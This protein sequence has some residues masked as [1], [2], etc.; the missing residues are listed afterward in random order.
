MGKRDDDKKDRDKSPQPSNP[1]RDAT[2]S[3]SKV[4]N[5]AERDAG[6]RDR[7]EAPRAP[8]P[9]GYGDNRWGGYEGGSLS[10]TKGDDS[11]GAPSRAPEPDGPAAPTKPTPVTGRSKQRGSQLAL[12]KTARP[13]GQNKRDAPAEK[14]ATPERRDERKPVKKDARPEGQT[15]RDAPSVRREVVCKA[16]PTGKETRPKGGAGSGKRFVPYIGSKACK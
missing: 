4:Q 13:E 3:P 16:P 14:R 11:Y 1:I 5:Q 8:D 7:P 6:V 15:K 12:N 10:G 2:P 9:A